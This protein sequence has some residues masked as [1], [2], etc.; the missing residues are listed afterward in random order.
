MC[1]SDADVPVN[2]LPSATT[3]ANTEVNLAFEPCLDHHSASAMNLTAIPQLYRHL[4]RWR[5]ILGVLSKYGLANWISLLDIEFA[6]EFFKDA[7][8]ESLARLT[9]E[10][11]IRLALSELGPTF[12]KLGQV[13]S[14]R[15]T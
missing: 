14:T 7:D 8:G 1:G 4:N 15:P 5:E 12:I 10:S 6:K 3:P 11:R 13:L 2:V 9:T